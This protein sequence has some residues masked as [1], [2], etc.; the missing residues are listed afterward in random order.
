[1]RS[2]IIVSGT[3]FLL[4]KNEAWNILKTEGDILFSEYGDWRNSLVKR[5]KKDY[6]ILVVFLSDFFR[7]SLEKNK[8]QRKALD[9]VNL[10]LKTIKQNIKKTSQPTIVAFS[11]WKMESVIRQ[12]DEKNNFKK[13]FNHLYKGLNKIKS[14]NSNFYLLDLDYQFGQVGYINAFDK[15]NWY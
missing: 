13:I 6:L 8:N 10:F 7:I 9:L 15:R 1:M 5:E 14:S 4:P 3:S 12:V 11:S 2:N